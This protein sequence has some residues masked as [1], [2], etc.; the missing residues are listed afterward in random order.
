M[1]YVAV[2][3]VP[4]ALAFGVLPLGL[5]LWGRRLPESHEVTRSAHVSAKQGDVLA[6]L[7]DAR[8]IPRWRKTV[9]RVAVIT[10][11]PTLRYREHGSQGALEIEV[12]EIHVPDRIVLRAV[13][14]RP[15][16]FSGTWTYELAPEGDGTRVTLTERGRIPSPF[17][18][19]VAT[20]VLGRA[21][22]VERTLSALARYLRR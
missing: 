19:L 7:R 18:R 13:P 10:S 15:M 6:L 11:E 20:Q 14:A 9:R 16:A 22:H 4:A 21:T 3:L 12:E 5:V 8:A 17:A 2:V 1:L